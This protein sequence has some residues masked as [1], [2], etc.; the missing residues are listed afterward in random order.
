MS[1]AVTITPIVL[2]IDDESAAD[3]D[4]LDNAGDANIIVHPFEDNESGILKLEKSYRDYDA[5]VLDAWGRTAANKKGADPKSLDDIRERLNELA[6][7]YGYK[8]PQCIYTGH[9]G[10]LEYLGETIPKFNK[11]VDPDLDRL[12]AWVREQAENRVSHRVMSQHADVFHV[13]RQNLLPEEKKWELVT[14]LHEQYS[15]DPVVIRRNNGLA[16]TFI[17]PIMEGLNTLGPQFMPDEIISGG[18]LNAD[19]AMRYL[20]GQNVDMK[21]QKG[22]VIKSFPQRARIVPEHLGWMLST[23]IKTPTFTGSHDYR[24][25]HTQYAHRAV[26][27]ALCEL[28][29]WYHDLIMSKHKK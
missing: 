21:D 8:I 19:S 13:F 1:E 25:R 27:N 29:I 10:D 7:K 12:F 16:R 15:K 4:F 22:V 28:L 20:I 24:D 14:L 11:D 3:K 26:V 17:E 6:I 2:W 23:V 18:R 5:V 9:M